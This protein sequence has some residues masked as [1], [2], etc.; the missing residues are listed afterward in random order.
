MSNNKGEY[1]YAS[2]SIPI[3]NRLQT[4]SS[5]R[6]QRNNLRIAEEE[7]AQKRD[8]LVKLQLQ[9]ENDCEGYRKQTLQMQHKVEA[10]SIAARLTT[11]KY[12]EGLSS[13]IDVQ[14]STATLLESRSRLLQCQ[15]MLAL[16]QKLANYYKGLPLL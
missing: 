13:A 11:R 8:E 9:A 1:V 15:L 7:L 6:R 14:T 12:E 3:F 2:V 4:L 10:D 5:I 16:K